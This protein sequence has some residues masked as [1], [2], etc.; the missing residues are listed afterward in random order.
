MFDDPAELLE[1]IRLGED[2]WLELK[3]VRFAGSRVSAPHRNSLA[4]EIAALANGKGGVCILGVSDQTRDIIGIPTAL[5]DAVEDFV[6][7]LCNDSIQPPPVVFLERLWLPIASGEKAAILKIDVPRSIF[8]HKSPGGYFHRVGS[9]KR[10]MQTEYLARLFQQRS[11]AGLIRFDEQVVAA[12]E[13][14]DL[15]PALWQRFRTDRTRDEPEAFLRKLGMV[16]EDDAGVIRP[17][18][19]GI[20]LAS[21]EPRRWLPNAFIQAVAYAGSKEAPVR[22]DSIYQ[23]DAKDISGPLDMQVIEASR[24]VVRNMRVRARKPVGR[25]DLP[26]FDISAVFEAVVN[27]V[28]HRDYA[29]YGAKIRLRLFDDRLEIYSPGS[30]PNTMTVESLM[31]RQVARNEAITSLLAKCPVPVGES[32]DWLA[33]DRQTLMDK[34]GEGVRIILESSERLAGR[35]PEYR[36]IDDAE[37]LLTIFAAKE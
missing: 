18:V 34:R 31:Y 17:T 29:I 24:F 14:G 23:L 16:R 28:A 32:T 26:Q 36:L 7:S 20:L 15:D 21:P 33:T 11:Q 5:L 13:I 3:E 6:R 4:D 22:P 19:A 12:A 37:L 1:K 2:S 27:A 30:L 25:V 8:V 9:S 10:Q 35:P